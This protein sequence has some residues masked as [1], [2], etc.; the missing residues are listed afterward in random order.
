MGNAQIFRIAAA[1]NEA[2]EKIVDGSIKQFAPDRTALIASLA[3]FTDD[4]DWYT[5][6]P[7]R[8]VALNRQAGKVIAEWSA[9]LTDFAWSPD[10]SHIALYTRGTGELQLME[11]D[12][13]RRELLRPFS[14]ID[15]DGEKLAG[16]HPEGN[17][18]WT[19][20]SHDLVYCVAA[21]RD[22]TSCEL[23]RFNLAARAEQT[24]TTLPG[25][26]GLLT[27]VP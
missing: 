16:E 15:I 14:P 21:S 11:R 12:S 8:L 3:P 20:D 24:L 23:R 19:P 22:S 6:D 7:Y 4:L 25:F 9:P 5:S 1:G 18:F 10:G 17:L 13:G 2:A 27:I 26:Q